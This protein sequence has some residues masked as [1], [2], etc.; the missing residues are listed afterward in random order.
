MPVK[1]RKR[2]DKGKFQS[3]N[4][5]SSDGEHYEVDHIE[6]HRISN[7]NKL[8]FLV[9]WKG[10]SSDD[11]TWESFDMFAYDAPSIAQDYLI[12]LLKEK[13]VKFEKKE[14]A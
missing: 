2:N 5:E 14:M 9:R 3:N 11:D 8:E 6:K 10:Y 4:S 13:K 7:K 1:K 12:K